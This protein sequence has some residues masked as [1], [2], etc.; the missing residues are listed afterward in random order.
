MLKIPHNALVFVGDGRKALFLRNDG[1]AISPNLRA[2]EVFE[3]V[4]PS[5]HDQG[6]DRPGRMSEAALPGRRS[7]VEPTDWH[8]IEEHHFARKVA[9]AMEKLVRT[10]RAKALIVVAPPRTL[11]E[12]RNSFHSDVKA[13]IVAEINKDLTKIPISEIERHLDAA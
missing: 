4:N 9:A 5:T 6:S 10:S 12:L 13:C 8:D 3:D 1:D 7:A 11:A 2:E